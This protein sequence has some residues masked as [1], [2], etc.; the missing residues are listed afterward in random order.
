MYA[1]WVE[2]SI[3]LVGYDVTTITAIIK[4][5]SNM[6]LNCMMSKTGAIT[7]SCRCAEVTDTSNTDGKDL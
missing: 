2:G 7:T 4:H 1:Q 5:F 3:I 6:F